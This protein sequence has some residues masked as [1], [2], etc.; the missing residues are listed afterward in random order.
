MVDTERVRNTAYRADIDGLRAIAVVSVFAY[1]LD[2]L[3]I[4]KGGFVGVDIFFV[5]SGYLITGIIA[6]EISTEKFKLS[7]FYRR[8]ALRILPAFVAMIVGV[9]IASVVLLPPAEIRELGRVIIG[10]SLSASNIVFYY[11]PGGY[12]VDHLHARPLL[13]TWSLGVEEQFYFI[14]PLLLW[15]AHKYWRDNLGLIVLVVGIASFAASIWAQTTDPNAA[16][17]L[18]P[19]RFW[20]LMLGAAGALQLIRLPSGKWWAEAIAGCG[21]VMIAWA[22]KYTDANHSLFFWAVA[23]CLGALLIILA[24]EKQRTIVG[25]G[26][27]IA[28]VVWVGLISYSLYLW[29]WP[30]IMFAKY[31]LLLPLN[32]NIRLIIVVVATL[33]AVVSWYFIERPFRKMPKTVSNRTVLL[34]AGGAIATTAAI[35]I[36]LLALNGIPQR[37]SPAAVQVSDYLY[38]KTGTRE[39]TCLVDSATSRFDWNTCL[40]PMNSERRRLIIFGD[41]H[42]ADL[43]QGLVQVVKGYD[44]RQVTM[45]YCRPLIGLYNEGLPFCSELADRFFNAYLKT[46]HPDDTILISQRW[47]ADQLAALSRTIQAFQSTGARVIVVGPVPEYKIALPRLEFA[48]LIW[49]KPN[50]LREQLDL[51]IAP[52]DT[53]VAH[54]AKTAKAG[55]VS[56]QNAICLNGACRSDVT[57]GVPLMMDTDHFTPEGSR[58]IAPTIAAAL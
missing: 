40:G 37:F 56:L 24:N 16:F 30:V 53:A 41:S 28:P 58:F 46:K 45:T 52:L 1:H 34:G 48:S 54:T 39:G 57:V 42:A 32:D 35:G 44:V 31:G 20:E 17:Y 27:S 50:L 6:R 11:S 3:S 7:S 4:A 10:A 47:S 18:L 21:L 33:L 15:A 49:S 5:I 38:G 51:G 22:I 8:R 23:P 2:L 25:R 36:V 9:T 26:L 29:H 13:H 43:W 19:A 12:F 55:Y 14:F